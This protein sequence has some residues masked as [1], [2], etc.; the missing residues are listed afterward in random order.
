MK[1]SKKWDPYKIV[2]SSIQN[3]ELLNKIIENNKKR[4]R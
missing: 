1:D 3:L 4:R 2:K